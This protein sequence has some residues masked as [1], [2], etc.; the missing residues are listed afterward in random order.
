MA[1]TKTVAKMRVGNKHYEILVDLELALKLRKG[2][3][4]NIQ[5]VLLANDVF[6]NSKTGEKPSSA[7]LMA[8]FGTS[9]IMQAA[10][11]IVQKGDIQLPKDFRDEQQDNKKKQVADWFIKNA[12][13]ARSGR[14]F[15]PQ[16]IENALSQAGVNISNQPIDQ[17]ISA[18]AESLK[19]IL[20]LRIETKKLAITIPVIYTGKAYGVVNQYK[21]REE[22]LS[23]G[24]L[25][26]FVNIPVGL[27]MEFY[28][29]LNSITHGSALSE[30]IKEK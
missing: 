11:K 21:E 14:P 5:N 12:V 30:E 10:T 8:A 23:D 15:T 9:D 4:V 25:K 26:V 2:D 6:L 18:I 27:Q 3:N 24:S 22:W 20:P 28:D 29:K 19:T 1:T 7:D 16:V 13:D 17:Q